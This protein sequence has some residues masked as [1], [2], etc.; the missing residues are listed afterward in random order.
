MWA[1]VFIYRDQRLNFNLHCN[2]I[3][4]LCKKYK[5]TSEGTLQLEV[6][7][8]DSL[9]HIIALFDVLLFDQ[10]FVLFAVLFDL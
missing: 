2:F 8:L 3:L 1:D 5:G 9:N 4:Q 7:L 10:F 6:V